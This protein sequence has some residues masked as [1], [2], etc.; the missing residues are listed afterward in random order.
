M[1]TDT[2]AAITIDPK[3][4]SRKGLRTPKDTT[5]DK[6]VGGLSHGVLAVWSI[7]VILPMLWTLVGSFKTTKEIFASPFGLPANWN[8]DNYVNAWVKNNFGGMFLNTV[9]VVGVALVLVMVLG[10][11][12]A[13]VLA[14][15]ALPGSR[16]I[17]YLMLAGLT[18]PVFL[19]IVPLFF[20][21]QGMGLL[22]TLPGLI[23]TYVAFALPFTVFF[24]FSF[25]KSLPYEIQ[26]AAYVDGA[27]E[28]RTFFQVMLPMAKPGMAAIAIMNFLGL[29]NQFLLPISL[30]TNQDNYVLSQGM[31]NFAS[32]AGYQVDFGAMFAAVIITIVPVL[33]V[34]VL[35]QRQLQGSVSQGTSK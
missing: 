18:F 15:F 22:N 25:F 27:G 2:R 12:C 35:F 1:S 33:V 24:L 16:V 19:A 4:T 26:E 34:Y 32:A 14:R 5:S 9:I 8:F 20:I 3:S 30:N 13:Y 10:A 17:Y 29:W 6:V 11:M 23:I 7:V 28:W 21:L 31:A